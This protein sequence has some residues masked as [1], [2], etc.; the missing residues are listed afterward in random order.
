VAKFDNP[1]Y[2]YSLIDQ[3]TFTG[4]LSFIGWSFFFIVFFYIFMLPVMMTY[5]YVISPI[6][7]AF[8]NQR[9]LVSYLISE[10]TKFAFSE[11][12]IAV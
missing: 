8:S 10:L 11:Q 3:L 6:M 9:F 12:K 4:I 5:G 2:V 1:E 7:R